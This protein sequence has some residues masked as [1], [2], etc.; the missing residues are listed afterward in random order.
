[1]LIV[2]DSA[3]PFF[4]AVIII[5][6]EFFE[7]RLNRAVLN[8]PVEVNDSRFEA[9][10]YFT[11]ANKP[12]LKEFGCRCGLGKQILMIRFGHCGIIKVTVLFI[13]RDVALEFSAVTHE[14]PVLYAVG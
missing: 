2:Y 5:S 3:A 6:R 8:P 7:I 10:Y 4:R 14:E 1:M 9:V 11:A 12:V 13:I